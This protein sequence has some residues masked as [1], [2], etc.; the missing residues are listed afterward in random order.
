MD[1][2]MEVIIISVWAIGMGIGMLTV[3]CAAIDGIVWATKQEK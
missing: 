1:K 2:V 3:M